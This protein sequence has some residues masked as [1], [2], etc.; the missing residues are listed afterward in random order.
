MPVAGR[1]EQSAAGGAAGWIVTQ[2]QSTGLRLLCY[3]ASPVLPQGEVEGARQI[4]TIMGF[5]GRVE[6]V[7]FLQKPHVLSICGIIPYSPCLKLIVRWRKGD[8]TNPLRTSEARESAFSEAPPAIGHSDKLSAFGQG[9]S[10]VELRQGNP[11]VQMEP[12]GLLVYFPG[13]GQVGGLHMAK[14][15]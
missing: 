5:S 4:G 8:M 12:C 7:G 14:R 6:S 15:P 3:V 11:A 13:C 2:S 9:P 1:S 10:L